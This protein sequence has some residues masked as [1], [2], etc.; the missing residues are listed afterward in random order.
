MLLTAAKLLVVAW[1]PGALLFRLPFAA[2]DRRAALPADERVFWQIV[3]SVALSI[4]IVLALAAL[5]RYSF[6]RLLA[7][8]L[9]IAAALALAARF[10]LRLHAPAP[11]PA[12]LVV[13]GLIALGAWRFFP[14]AEF[15]T[16]GKDPGAYVNEG[17]LIAQRGTLVY[18]DPT[19][20]SVPPFARDLFFPSH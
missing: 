11:T 5:G 9:G 18:D 13:V 6:E 3:V 12:S 1:L 19:V 8:D 10:R 15:V 20:A 7:A 16:G 17:I 14:P 4:S 2:R